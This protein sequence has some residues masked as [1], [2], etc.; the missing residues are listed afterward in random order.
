VTLTLLLVAALG[1][2]VLAYLVACFRDPLRYALPPYAVSIQF[3][4][5]ISVGPGPFGSVSSLL[6]ILLGVSLLAQLITARPASPRLPLVVPVWLAFLALCGFSI[7]W[8]INAEET[9]SRFAVLSSLVLLFVALTLTRFDRAA[10][11]RFESALILGGVLVVGYGLAQLLLLGGFPTPDGG[12]A[13]FGNDLLGPNNQA[14]SLLLP[15]AISAGRALSGSIRW[16]AVH[17]AALLLLALGVVMTGSRGGLLAM[18]ITLGAIVVFG[19]VKRAAAVALVAAATV[20]VGVVLLI[21]PGGIGQRQLELQTDASGRDSIWTIGLH[22]C[23]EYCL[24]GAGWG[25]FPTVYATELPEVPEARILYRGSSFEAHNIFLLVGVE[26]GVV[27]LL[28]L[29][30]ALGVALAGALRLPVAMRGPPVAALLGIVS[31]GFF[32]SNLEYKFFWAVLMY[33]VVAESLAATPL[34]GG[35]SGTWSGEG[36]LA[37]RGDVR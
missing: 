28:L 17:G 34:A 36:R 30:M 19:A 2:L 29:L 12:A 27:G 22:A 9:A 7:F 33:V 21:N 3:S 6:G 20:V 8:S 16:R 13:R 23:S 4:S 14:A 5:L 10:F 24:T 18:V 37:L 1:P 11:D 26:A 25:S 31:S 35:S 15:I 32:L